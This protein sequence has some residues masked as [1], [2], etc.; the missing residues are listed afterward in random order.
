MTTISREDVKDGKR[1]MEITRT[2]TREKLL[3]GFK[4]RAR[5]LTFKTIYELELASLHPFR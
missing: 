5:E 2:S 3:I 4:K 1:E